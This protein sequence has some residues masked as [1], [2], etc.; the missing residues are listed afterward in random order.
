MLRIAICDDDTL[1]CRYIK[2]ILLDYGKQ[3]CLSVDVEI[4]HGGASLC[5]FWLQE[6]SFEL[7]F[8]DIEMENMNG[9]DVGQ[10]FRQLNSNEIVQI[11]YISAKES[12]A[13]QL[14]QNR[15]FDFLVKPIT[16]ERLC[17]CLSEYIRIHCM[18]PQYFEYMIERHKECVAVSQILYFESIR[19][20]LRMM[21]THGEVF[22]YGKISDV[23]NCSFSNQFISIHQ[24][25][26]VNAV[27]ITAFHA[28][29][30]V[31]SNRERLKVSRSHQKYV[32]EY[33]L[34]IQR[35]KLSEG[36]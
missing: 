32:K 25:Y 29:E 10:F 21:T 22:F 20:R 15:P 36:I 4:F 18:H 17:A 13:M 12:Y 5:D 28:D 14:F 34:S 1:V 16:D 19:K 26:L 24:S 31:V 35:G 9:I 11:V 8:L 23:S 6:H 2:R 30:V 7:V 33:L 27:H 3:N